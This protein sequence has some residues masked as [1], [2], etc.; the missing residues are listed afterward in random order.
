MKVFLVLTVCL[1]LT[2]AWPM[3]EE[4][5]IVPEVEASKVEKA[6]ARFVFVQAYS[7]VYQ[8]VGTSTL[9]TFP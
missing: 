9:S 8:T 6:E 5:G 1:N 3:E 7:T 2:L 4:V